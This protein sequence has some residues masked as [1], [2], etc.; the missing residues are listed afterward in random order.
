M[1]QLRLNAIA[2]SYSGMA[3]SNRPLR[4]ED[5]SFSVMRN[6]TAGRCRDSCSTNPSARAMSVS[7]VRH[8][9]EHA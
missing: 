4:S 3:S 5:L 1:T 7:G 2:T 8:V 9:I 6:R